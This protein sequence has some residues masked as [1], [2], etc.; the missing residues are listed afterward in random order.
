MKELCDVVLTKFV[1]FTRDDMIKLITPNQ[2]GVH[3]N[4]IEFREKVLKITC[5]ISQ[6][7]LRIPVRATTCQHLECFDLENYLG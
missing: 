7:R 5:P 2:G 1:K 3:D 6:R 4:D